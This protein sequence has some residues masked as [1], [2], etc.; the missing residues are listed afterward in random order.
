[1]KF[2]WTKIKQYAFNEFK[3][4]VARNTLSDYLYFNKA[5]K[6]H[7]NA[8]NL[9]L[10]VVIS[11]KGNP[12]TLYSTELTNEPKGYTVPEKDLLRIIESL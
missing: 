2:K 9:Q 6:I 4:T 1:M 10:W 7:T 5:F 3:R 8:S 12:T 11:H